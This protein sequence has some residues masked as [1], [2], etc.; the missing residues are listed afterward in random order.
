MVQDDKGH[1]TK[2]RDEDRESPGSSGR[3][4]GA[5]VR[6]D[7]R[8]KAP[9]LEVLVESFTASPSKKKEAEQND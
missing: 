3:S 2:A 5:R 8:V 4:G 9:E 6:I 7:S 1:P